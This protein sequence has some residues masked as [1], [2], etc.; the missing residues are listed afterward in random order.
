MAFKAQNSL[1]RFSGQ[2]EGCGRRK[3]LKRWGVCPAAAL[4]LTSSPGDP[5]SSPSTCPSRLAISTKGPC[6]GKQRT[7][8]LYD[9]TDQL[10]GSFGPFG[11]ERPGGCPRECLR[12]R[13]CPTE[14][15]TGDTLGTLFGHTPEPGARRAPGTPRGTLRRTPPF[16]GTLSGTLPGHSGPKGPRDPCSWSAGSQDSSSNFSEIPESIFL[17]FPLEHSPE[18][19]AL[20]F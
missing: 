17:Q 13:G 7:R 19:R 2:M 4:L 11:P 8:Q 14:C 20:L 6:E 18:K 1:E 3:D 16:S 9:P 12:K 10:Q 15:P 5:C